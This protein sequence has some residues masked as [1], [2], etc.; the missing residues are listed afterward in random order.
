M[1]CSLRGDLLADPVYEMNL[2]T[3]HLESGTA[4]PTAEAAT[5]LSDDSKRL[6]LLIVLPLFLCCYGGSCIIYCI[7]KLIRNCAK[8]RRILVPASDPVKPV[9]HTQPVSVQM[10]PAM[11]GPSLGAREKQPM[12]PML[13]VPTPVPLRSAR[14][15]SG[16]RTATVSP[17]PPDN[18]P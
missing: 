12:P 13:M 1:S 5:G 6:A 7:H 9:P 16:R 18:M 15:L 4:A 3:V 17:A 10:P 11:A 2:V 14:P 8:A